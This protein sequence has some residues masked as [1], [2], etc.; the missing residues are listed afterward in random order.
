MNDLQ[1]L[2]LT[3]PKGLL[4]KR[5]EPVSFDFEGKTYQGF[6]GDTIASA[7]LAN[8]QRLLSRS[9]K[10]HRPRGVLT[11]AGQDA[12]SLVQ[13]DGEANV[14]ADRAC[15][16]E[17]Q[18]IYGQNY[19]GSLERDFDA[20][21]NRCGRF[22]P[23]GWYYR[24]FFRPLGAWDRW[25]KL[26]RKKGGLGTL[27]LDRKPGYYDKAYLFHDVAVIG[28]GP[29]GLSAAL[30]AAEAGL[31][32]MLVEE[33]PLLGGALSYHRFDID[34]CR[35]ERLR[36]ELISRAEL[37]TN[38]DRY[39]NATCN[40]WFKDNYLSIIQGQRMYKVRAKEC[41]L[42]TGAYEQHVVFRNNDVP[43]VML[44]SAVDRLMNWY[45]VKPGGRAVV[46]TGNDQGYMTALEMQQQGIQVAGIVDM[47][48]QPAN[49]DLLHRVESLQIP[50]LS[51]ST[52]CEAIGGRGNRA[53]RAVDIRTISSPGRVAEASRIIECDVLCM[54]AGFMPAYPLACQAGARLSYRDETAQFRIDQLPEHLHVAG[55]VNGLH[56]LDA[57]IQDGSRAAQIC[58]H[59]LQGVTPV[60]RDVHCEQ[61]TNFPWP[62]F[63]HPKGRDFVDF[64]EDLQ[65]KDIVDAT[66]LGYRDVQLVKRFSTVGMGP[67]Q[68]RHSALP[69]ARLIAQATERSVSETGVTTA[70]PP[71]APEKLAHIAGRIFDPY[72]LTAMHYRHIELGAQMMPAGNWQRPAYYGDPGERDACVQAESLNVRHK[73]GLIDVSTLGGIE[74]FGSD[75][76]EFMN[77]IYTFTFLKQPVGKTC[78]AAMTNEYGVVIDDGVACRMSDDHFY[79]T[80]TTNGVTQAYREMLKWNAQWR[81]DVHLVN[82]TS[83][84]AAVNLAGPDS[85]KVLEKLTDLDVSAKAFPYLACREGEVANIANARL[86]RVGFVGELGYEIHVP[87]RHG[88][89]LW[90]ALMEAGKE[91]SIKP[92]GVE[93]QRLLRLE[94]GHI[95]V[96]QDTDGMTH[97]GEVDLNWAIAHNK[98]FYVGGRSVDIHMARLHKRK[99]VGFKL[100]KNTAKP[101]EGHLVLNGTDVSGNVTS[102]EYSPTLDAIIGM[103]YV[104]FEQSA[105]G[106]RFPIKVDGGACVAAQVVKLPFYD[107]EASRQ[108]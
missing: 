104:S 106:N 45:A 85:R 37:H 46:L 102:C 22:M 11:M 41:I 64:D 16:A 13:L 92:F 65:A 3:E 79:V 74:I 26:I 4:L 34:G 89:C 42:A 83:A 40:G 76:A 96:G 93:T 99:L 82:V 88:T 8:G 1:N 35:T 75:A 108:I 50:V 94:K 5:G 77:R 62:I 95:I 84:L 90:D 2:R 44:C 54:S 87:S 97:P 24:A 47:R 20:Y 21:L 98:P 38:I 51:E 25:E 19:T 49:S 69:T 56:E 36:D 80:A 67:S 107:P 103:A 7:L 10:Y 78:Y 59:N 61:Q 43:G 81:L 9:F 57:V 27:D 15:I 60:L 32:V 55:S 52:V 6:A 53:L 66:R 73:V 28:A 30:T 63:R 86:M 29:A 23:V 18:D 12:N 14:L 39:V 48:A 101:E 33:N 100:P 17:G 68:G 71:F 58:I 70:R 105:I 31:S 72:R 91:F